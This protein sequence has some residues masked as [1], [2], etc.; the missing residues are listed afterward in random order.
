MAKVESISKANDLSI[1]LEHHKMETKVYSPGYGNILLSAVYTQLFIPQF[2][3]LLTG[4]NSFKNDSLD[5]ALAF[6]GRLISHLNDTVMNLA[7]GGASVTAWSD[8]FEYN[9]SDPALFDIK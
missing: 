2:L 5:A 1:I 4:N 6:S 3:T 9:I 7:S 8:I